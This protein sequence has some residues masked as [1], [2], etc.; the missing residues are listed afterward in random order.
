MNTNTEIP[1]LL[2]ETTPLAKGQ[3]FDILE[4]LPFP[5]LVLD[6]TG[7]VSFANHR[8]NELLNPPEKISTCRDLS[9]YAEMSVNLCARLRE[10]RNSPVEWPVTMT[11]TLRRRVDKREF[12]VELVVQPLS[13]NGQSQWLVTLSDIS[14]FKRK[15]RE[16]AHMAMTDELT[17]LFNRRSFMHSFEQ[18]I[19]RARRYH[20]PVSLMLID[21]DHFKR[22]NDEYG[23]QIGDLVLQRFAETVRTTLREIDV[24]GR[25]GGEEFAVMM[26]ETDLRSARRVAERVRRSVLNKPVETQS[27]V[28][29]YSIS[30]GVIAS[31]HWLLDTETMLRHADAALYAAKH[32]GRNNVKAGFY[33]VM[34]QQD[35]P[36]EHKAAY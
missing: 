36:F 30:A 29:N 11:A 16:L 12:D 14:R 21:I 22:V 3:G 27:G 32:S 25:I 7:A 4:V 24:F 8:A 6:E 9:D 35:L 5:L 15:E 17:G 26:P 23:H 2:P 13:I 19:E 28:I 20:K 1:A 18:E 31:N 34:Q 10:L 33:P